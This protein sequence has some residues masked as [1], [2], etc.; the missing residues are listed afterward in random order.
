MDDQPGLPSAAPDRARRALSAGLCGLLSLLLLLLV[1]QRAGGLR[2]PGLFGV[3]VPDALIMAAELALAGAALVL[4]VRTRRPGLAAPVLAVLA[5]AALGCGLLLPL[6]GL[7]EDSPSGDDWVLGFIGLAKEPYASTLVL[8]L[9]AALRPGTGV[10]VVAGLGL[11]PVVGLLGLLPARQLPVPRRLRT[12]S[13]AAAVLAA[14]LVLR[15]LIRALGLPGLLQWH[16]QQLD[17][18][19]AVTTVVG[20]W[21]LVALLLSA[22]AL[23]R[24]RARPLAVALPFALLIAW[25]ALLLTDPPARVCCYGYSAA[26]ASS[27]PFHDYGVLLPALAVGLLPFAIEAGRRK[28]KRPSSV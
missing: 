15:D 13:L 18:A 10:L 24:G 5:V 9:S 11:L 19:D 17:A 4:A 8:E 16:G 25:A 21:A 2:D 14:V 26:Q 1:A 3:P 23:L 7:P 27:N 20:T 6:G 12:A 28:V 22:L